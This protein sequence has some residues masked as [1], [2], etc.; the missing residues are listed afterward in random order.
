ML[1]ETQLFAEFPKHYLD[2]LTESSQKLEY[3][4]NTTIMNQGSRGTSMYVVLVGRLKVYTLDAEGN[5]TILAFLNKGD[6][7]GELALFD[8]EP[9]SAS[10]VTM[11]KSRLL[12]LNRQMLL[13]FLHRHPDACMP[14]FRALTQRIRSIDEVVC[15]LTQK[16]VYGRLRRTLQNQAVEEGG[17]LITPRL[18]HQELADMVGSSREM[19]SRILKELR[20]GEYINIESK[21]IILEKKLPT[22]W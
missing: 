4:K 12:K 11:E 16:D 7:V 19:I 8:E 22:R 6:F 5:Q 10:V 15:N 3:K 9:R 21:R 17:R 2:E 14:I 20:I 18:T 13:D 1:S